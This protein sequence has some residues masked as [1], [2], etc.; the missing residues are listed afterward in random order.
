MTV[1]KLSHHDVPPHHAPSPVCYDSDGSIQVIFGPKVADSL[2]STIV[3]FGNEVCYT[4]KMC[5]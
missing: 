5:N 3:F 1:P 2:T 4:L